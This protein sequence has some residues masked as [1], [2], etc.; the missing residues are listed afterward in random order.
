MEFK[1]NE[2]IPVF[3]VFI[4]E[5]EPKLVAYYTERIKQH[6]S[7]I[8]A[9]EKHFVKANAASTGPDSLLDLVQAQIDFK[10]KVLGLLIDHQQAIQTGGFNSIFQDFVSAVEAIV[11]PL[12]DAITRDEAFGKFV[13]TKGDG[14]IILLRKA[15]INGKLNTRLQ[16]RKLLNFFRR[17]F[18]LPPVSLINRRKRSIPFKNMARQFLLARYAEAVLDQHTRIFKSESGNLLRL[19]KFDDD[20]DSIFQQLLTGVN[21]DLAQDASHKNKHADFFHSLKKETKAMMESI[22]ADIRAISQQVFASFDEAL[23]VVGTVELPDSDFSPTKTNKIY[24]EIDAIY[25]REM[26]LWKNTYF[27]LFD[28]W[29]VDVEITSLYY[30]V[31][32]RHNQ[33]KLKI[34]GFIA[35]NIDKD[36][37][38]IR[39]FI[40]SSGE[41]ISLST[42]SAKKLATVIAEEREKVNKQLID[43]MLAQSVVRLTHC[44]SEDFDQLTTDTLDLANRVSGKRGFIKSKN[45]EQGVRDSEINY[46]SPAELLRFEALP[47]FSNKIKTLKELVEN[48][49][50]KI[51][52]ALLSLGTVCDFTLESAVM[53]I[54]AEKKSGGEASKI[55]IQGYDRALNQLNHAR[56]I[57]I[58]IQTRITGE[59]RDAVNIFNQE[60]QKLKNTEN[61]LELNM[62]IARIKAVE[63]SKEIRRQFLL[64]LRNVIPHI[65]TVVENTRKVI[66]LQIDEVKLKMGIT[67]EKV[68]V[69][70]ELSEF[71]NESRASLKQLPYVY[72][73][74][75]QLQPANEERFFVN[76]EKELDALQQ[77]FDNWQKDRFITC[78]VIGEKGS[79]V[80]SLI[81]YF[82]RLIPDD[83][84]VIRHTLGEKN[85]TSDQYFHLFES[86]L[87]TGKIT[88]NKQLIDTLNDFQGTRII[89][90]ENLQHMF[91]KKVNGFDN[92]KMFFELMSHTS[93]KVLWIGAY[94]PASWAYLDKTI[95][96]S[97]Y[98]T[99]E[100]FLEKLNDEIIREIIFKRNRLSGYQLKFIPSGEI[101]LSKS[102]QK[103][104]DAEKQ[105]YLQKQFFSSLNKMANGNISLAQLY[106][107]RSTQNVDD[108]SISIGM[109]NK[110][111]F[112]FIKKLPGNSLFVLQV[113]LLH[114]GLTLENYASAM[115][116]TES[117]SRNQL[118]PMLEKGLLIRPRKKFNINPIIY[119]QVNDYL[120]SRNFIH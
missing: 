47:H 25:A 110:L 89:V 114:D 12:D 20:A 58:D 39:S 10:A 68:A 88:S 44:F 85:L 34:N 118:I 53:L 61:V 7:L 80:T 73:R 9:Y 115:N 105:Q 109:I 83:I 78:A 30:S 60:I 41:R 67:V 50:E 90:L 14:P 112:S 113:L 91:L 108:Q 11:D 120:S 82:L 96:I 29:A 106:W 27:T 35:S 93:K 63:Q 104:D 103:L 24:E 117:V 75:Y 43:R 94:T 4:R 17:I 65:K 101:T 97:N 69:S 33:L 46:I 98:F 1:T 77:S 107:L 86:I 74:L 13:Y 37:A 57:I 49:L 42:T 18:K 111:D 99:E 59:L 72:Q 8:T 5:S 45:Y 54:E 79:G 87:G 92:M 52:V 16:A 102:F 23:P 19:W 28:D 95:S 6:S 62:K 71:L 116:E 15:L 64:H 119:K 26:Q 32:D 81:N 3:E 31:Y 36:F 55:A 51:R 84:Q 56:E 22:S 2:I 21:S 76:R 100:I 70:F 38:A 40:A 66:R 48:Q